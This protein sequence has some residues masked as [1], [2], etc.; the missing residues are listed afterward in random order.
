MKITLDEAKCCTAGQEVTTADRLAGTGL[1]PGRREREGT[2]T[3]QGRAA[4]AAPAPQ[5]QL[6]EESA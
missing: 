5:P 2:E 3:G 4:G 6:A 1:P